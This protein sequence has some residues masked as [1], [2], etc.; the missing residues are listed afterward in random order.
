MTTEFYTVT[1]P[2][3]TR[4]FVGKDIFFLDSESRLFPMN[5]STRLISV[6]VCPRE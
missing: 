2:E 5:F 1:Y 6:P 4:G 3:I